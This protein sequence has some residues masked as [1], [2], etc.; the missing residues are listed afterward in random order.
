MIALERGRDEFQI[1]SGA[2]RPARAPQHGD[3]LRRIAIEREQRLGE[4]VRALRIHRI[5]RLDARPD[6]GGDGAVTLD[7]KRHFSLP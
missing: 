3:R 4:R 1:P 2:E 6:D 5:A 7:V